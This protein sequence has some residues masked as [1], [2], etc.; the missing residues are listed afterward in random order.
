MGLLSALTECLWKRYLKRNRKSVKSEQDTVEIKDISLIQL[1]SLYQQIVDT[2]D[3]IV[4]LYDAIE[5]YFFQ[6]IDYEKMKSIVPLWM[7]NAGRSAESECDKGFYEQLR[8]VYNDSVSNRI[9][10]WA[11]VQGVLAAF[12]DRV[13]TVRSFLEVIYKYLPA[14]CLY[15]DCEYEKCNRGLDAKSDSVHAAIN[16]LFVSL[17]SA[18]DLFTKVVYECFN[19]DAS[20]FTTYRRLKSR[21]E[22]IL[23]KKSN[24][25]FDE[26]KADGLLYSE[27]VCVRIACTFRDE[28]IHNGAWDYRCAIYYPF[29]NNKPVEPF[30]LMPDLDDGGHLMT[31]GSR[32]KFYAQNNKINVLLPGFVKDVMDVLSKTVSSLIDLL[33]NKT[34]TGNKEKVTEAAMLTM[35][36]N[37]FVSKKVIM[38]DKYT[39]SEL[40]NDLDFLMP[41]FPVT[42]MIIAELCRG[43]TLN[44]SNG[45]CLLSCGLSAGRPYRMPMFVLLLNESANLKSDF[46]LA[47]HL[48]KEAYLMTDN[49]YNRLKKCTYPFV[50]SDF[51][52]TLEKTLPNRNPDELEIEEKELYNRLPNRFKVYRGMCDDEKKSGKFGISWTLDAEY[53][54][55]YVFFKKN[56]VHG[57]V[58]WRAEMEIDKNEIFAVWGVVG[59]EKEIVINSTKCKNVEFTKVVRNEE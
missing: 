6:D 35:M 12:Q 36:R 31:S 11:D 25:C 26:L 59:K 58:G 56:E 47:Y 4:P 17:C 7:L 3:A 28:F 2:A 57:T 40:I 43:I 53:A 23:Y 52:A 19:Y 16:N 42:Y 50:L 32:N 46:K 37:Q 51:L 30:V 5:D 21:T 44:L 39:E 13:V 41:Q 55:N 15:E 22:N 38:G 33:Q 1:K 27:P 49:I 18:F 24:Y 8:Q 10:H 14:Y 29:V 54:I 48:L 34:V 20:R 45:C 9:I